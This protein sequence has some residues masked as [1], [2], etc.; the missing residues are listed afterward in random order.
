MPDIEWHRNW[1]KF[2]FWRVLNSSP[3]TP[4][5]S[6]PESRDGKPLLLT[7]FIDWEA[8][9]YSTPPIL[10]SDVEEQLHQGR[11]EH[12]PLD[13]LILSV[14]FSNNQEV[15]N[16]LN[17]RFGKEFHF[18]VTMLE[19]YR[20]CPYQFYLQYVLGL[21]TSEE[22]LFEIDA[23]RWGVI[24]H[25]VLARLYEH[26]PI[27]PE[28]IPARA[29]QIAGQ[30]LAAIDLPEFW[31]QVT[32]R[33]LD[34]LFR[35]I[36]RVE[37]EIREQGFVPYRT[38]TRLQGEV[39]NIYVKGRIDRIDQNADRL[40]IIDYKTGGGGINANQ[41]MEKTHLQLPIYCRLLSNSQDFGKFI[42]ENMGVYNLRDL[43]LNWL[44][45]SKFS[46]NELVNAATAN[47]IEIVDLIRSGNFKPEN[48]K[49]DK[50]QECEF[51]FT[52]GRREDKADADQSHGNT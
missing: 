46:V 4:F 49:P 11:L 41:V 47:L 43:H 18:H 32:E 50:C 8:V 29:K 33:V 19:S 10:Y 21:E 17:R 15:R 51:K 44:A 24:A 22:P 20:Y 35:G 13:E 2:H 34:N 45:S 40:R 9:K 5:L 14:D 38:E 39:N 26:G 12:T 23:Q 1:Q 6:Y 42:V 25:Q 31:S 36:V 7:P 3:H 27:D 30:V 16:E 48:V 28:E 52:C 37:T